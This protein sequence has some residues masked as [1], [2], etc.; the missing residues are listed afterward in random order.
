MNVSGGICTR[1]WEVR[2][3]NFSERVHADFD[4][5]SVVIFLGFETGGRECSSGHPTSPHGAQFG[6]QS[7]A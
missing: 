1:N 3:T 5:I 4:V 2:L 7:I 6:H